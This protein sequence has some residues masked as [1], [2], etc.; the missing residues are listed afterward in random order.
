MAHPS[1]R[2][3]DWQVYA[4]STEQVPARL[5]I[6]GRSIRVFRVGSICV[7][8]GA[9][10][11][12]RLEEALRDQHS[13]VVELAKRFDPIL[14][15]RF[16]ARMTQARITQVI[17]PSDEVLMNALAHVRGRQQLTVRLIGPPMQAVERPASGTDYLAR[18]LA[19]Q[20][21]P[22]EALPVRDAVSRFI[23]DERVQPGRGG[24]R[25]TVFHLVERT[26]VAAYIEATQ[27]ASEK[28]APWRVSL[29]GPWPPFA[30]A[31]ELSQ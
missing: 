22:A 5:R 7:L 10:Q 26:D 11:E 18:R 6:A 31:P 16:G 24:I 19:A 23:V 29:T 30:F 20:A 14:P 28:I 4:L 27:D 1:D 25:L 9:P 13:I 21:F 15:V 12:I 2:N 3:E 8:A 17:R